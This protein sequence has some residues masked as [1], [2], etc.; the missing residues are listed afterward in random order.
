MITGARGLCTA[1]VGVRFPSPPSHQVRVS[2][3]IDPGAVCWRRGSSTL[4]A[5]RSP[6]AQGQASPCAR[7]ALSTAGSGARP[8]AA[9]GRRRF[10]AEEY[11]DG[12]SRRTPASQSRHRRSS[13]DVDHDA[14]I[15]EQR[16]C[17]AGAG[18][19]RTTAGYA[20]LAGTTVTNTGPT[21]VSG[22]L[23]LSPGS[24]VTGF[25][26][27]LVV[28]GV[29]NVANAQAVQAQ[30]D[31][32][33]AYNDAAGR[34]PATTVLGDASAGL[35][36]VAGVYSG[37]ALDLT[38]TL[39]LDAQGDPGAVFIFQAASTLITASAAACDC[40]TA[41]SRATSSGRSEVRRRSGPP[42]SSRGRSS[43]SRRSG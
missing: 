13:R 5:A 9:R 18:E 32:V 15:R 22:N 12:D 1:E 11:P 41:P 16:A 28:G 17:S 23:G 33:T 14:R 31:L 6:P 8:A 35:T 36:L 38:G 34:T 10:W 40:S 42:R 2:C 39:T 24:S 3:S 27:G 25:P 37:G 20:V 29:Q 19:P 26:P 7:S 21:L 4:A 30:S 43:P